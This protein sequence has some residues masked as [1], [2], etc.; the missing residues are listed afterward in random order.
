MSAPLDLT[1]DVVKLLQALVDIESV[2]GHESEIADQ[3]EQALR[4]H[5]HLRCCG[6]GTWSSREPNSAAPSE[7]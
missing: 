5:P 4:L 3:V 1:G 7:W 2:S 6:M